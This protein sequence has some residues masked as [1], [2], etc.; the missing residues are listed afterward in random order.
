M[1][2]ENNLILN[3]ILFSVLNLNNIYKYRMIELTIN[4]YLLF[5][6]ELEFIL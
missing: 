5:I 1:I 2:K 3:K 4:N 6:F